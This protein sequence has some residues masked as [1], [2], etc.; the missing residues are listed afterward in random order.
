MNPTKVITDRLTYLEE[1]VRYL[2]EEN[3]NYLAILD[4]L[5]S[6]NDF[7]ADLNRDKSTE[8]IFR[9]TLTQ[10]S[11]LFPFQGMGLL[12]I[13]EDNSFALTVCEPQSCSDE[14][15][16]D[17]DRAIMDGTFAWSLN[18]NQ[19]ITAP[20]ASGSQTLLFH[21]IAT[22]P[23]IRGMFIGRLQGNPAHIDSPSL[24]AISNV[25]LITAYA[26]ESSILYGVLQENGVTTG[27]GI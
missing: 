26:M 10:L 21:V 23:R 2:E 13:G 27:P 11:R 18:R 22:W 19:A 3:R 6:C 7:Q 8:G 17:I 16:F 25:L 1:R 24:H 20:A 12:E 9:A 14:L 4:M 5:A 15:S